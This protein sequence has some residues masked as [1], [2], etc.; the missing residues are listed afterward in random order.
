MPYG[1]PD[2]RTCAWRAFAKEASMDCKTHALVQLQAVD[3]LAAVQLEGDA[4]NVDAFRSGQLPATG[5][6][7]LILLES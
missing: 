6:N 5:R 7:A 4:L 3:S 2:V 1:Q